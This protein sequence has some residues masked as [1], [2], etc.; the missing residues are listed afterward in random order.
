MVQIWGEL[1]YF[2]AW[3]GFATNGRKVILFVRTGEQELTLSEPHDWS[4]DDEPTFIERICPRD[5]RKADW[6]EIQTSDD[7]DK[8]LSDGEPSSH[9]PTG[10]GWPG[11]STWNPSGQSLSRPNVDSEQQGDDTAPSHHDDSSSRASEHSGDFFAA[12]PLASGSGSG[13]AQPVAPVPGPASHVQLSSFDMDVDDEGSQINVAAAGHPPV[14]VALPPLIA[15]P[16]LAAVPPPVVPPPL[17]AALLPGALL[18]GPG[19]P[20]R[21]TRIATDPQAAKKREENARACAKAF[22]IRRRKPN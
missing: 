18:P 4:A 9:G 1:V 7:D 3:F 14:P 21:S 22:S 6:P 11:D 2:N 12:G 20:R 5:E 17:P 8:W 16:H 13:P 19:G 15:P 10:S